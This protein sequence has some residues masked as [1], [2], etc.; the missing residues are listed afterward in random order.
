MVSATRALSFDPSS[1]LFRKKFRS[2]ASAGNFSGSTARR[3]AVVISRSEEVRRNGLLKI[4][5]VPVQGGNPPQNLR[6]TE[7]INYCGIGW[8][9]LLQPTL[10]QAVRP[11]PIA[12]FRNHL[13]GHYTHFFMG[14]NAYG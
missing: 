5:G 2:T 12:D 14:D 6:P 7:K 8:G 10:L 11:F 3:A 9:C 13:I 4:S 1:G